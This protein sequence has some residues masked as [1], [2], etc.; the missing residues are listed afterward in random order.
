MVE[1]SLGDITSVLAARAVREIIP[2]KMTHLPS[3]P[4][5]E[6]S[7]GDPMLAPMYEVL[8]AMG[9]GEN[10][11]AVRQPY[12]MSREEVARASEAF[13]SQRFV[14]MAPTL[15]EAHANPE[16]L[17]GTVAYRPES[18]FLYAE[19]SIETTE[20]EAVQELVAFLDTFRNAMAGSQDIYANML[21]ERANEIED[22]LFFL[23]QSKYK[24]GVAGLAAHWRVML[25]EL[26]YLDIFVPTRSE[27]PDPIFKG[28]TEEILE[29]I[30]LHFPEDDPLRARI[31]SGQDGANAPDRHTQ[32]ILLENWAINLV[33]LADRMYEFVPPDGEHEIEVNLIAAST[34]QLHEGVALPG[35]RIE[36][37]MQAYPTYAYY[38][39]GPD[40]DNFMLNGPM[41]TGSRRIGSHECMDRLYAM[42]QMLR[43]ARPD[44]DVQ[45][46]ALATVVSPRAR[47]AE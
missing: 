1:I 44:L 37:D 32:V 29:D 5:P 10:S 9:N 15:R 23:S 26:P 40:T 3:Q 22:K 2:L 14:A 38:N 35:H 30:L 25:E 17:Q 31:R 6:N 47:G 7:G 18:D 45:L 8:T 36:P 39:A 24:Q 41:V 13:D 11:L 4:H 16:E 46:P 42:H 28:A 43:Q 34:E 12:Q 21:V 19:A 20:A 27:L 33:G